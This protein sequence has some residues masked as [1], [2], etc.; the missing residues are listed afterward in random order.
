LPSIKTSTSTASNRESSKNNNKKYVL[1]KLLE[2]S[3]KRK[4]IK[5]LLEVHKNGLKPE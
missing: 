5:K 2:D 3:E 1:D 4:Q